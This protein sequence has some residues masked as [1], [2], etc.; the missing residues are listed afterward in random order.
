MHIPPGAATARVFFTTLFFSAGVLCIPLTR[1][2]PQFPLDLKCEVKPLQVGYHLEVALKQ[3]C[4]NS[5][6]L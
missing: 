6:A 5:F 4:R 2:W 3:Y 1:F